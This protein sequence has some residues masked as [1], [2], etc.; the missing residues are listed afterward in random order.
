MWK[1]SWTHRSLQVIQVNVNLALNKLFQ[2]LFRQLDLI[3]NCP[4][5]LKMLLKSEYYKQM[6]KL[7]WMIIIELYLGKKH[8]DS[9]KGDR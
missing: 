7:Y 9:I 6:T 2:Y 4:T 5:A 3:G 1:L 8:L